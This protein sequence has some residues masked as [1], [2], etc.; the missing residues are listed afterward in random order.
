M[1]L[2]HVLSI[3][4]SRFGAT[5]EVHGVDH[6]LRAEART[7]L[8]LVEALAQH[9]AIPFGRTRIEVGEGG[10]LQAR[11]REGRRRALLTAAGRTGASRI[12]TAHHADDRA[13]T[14][15]IR[16][17][18]GARPEGL[19]VLGPVDGL[20][21]RPLVRARKADVVRHLQR[22]HLAFASDPSNENHRFLRVRVRHE[23]LPL[24]EALSP[25]IVQHLTALADEVG[26]GPPPRLVDE[27]GR[28]ISLRRAHIREVRRAAGLGRN[29][30]IR[31]SG[32]RDVVVAPGVR[33][34]RLD[35]GSPAGE[36]VGAVRAQKG[37][38]KP[39]KSG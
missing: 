1:A 35:V 4:S 29:A 10:N 12:A 25:A 27:D 3:L 5:L 14:F 7:E 22:H 19:G 30:R 39:G 8:D 36:S 26:W 17:L 37:D 16:L 9:L 28:P 11:A 23:L 24:L 20:F 18:H 38:A 13:E 21:I 32:G 33:A 2:L 6:G 15:L 34:A 31:I